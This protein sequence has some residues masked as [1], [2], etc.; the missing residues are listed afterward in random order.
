MALTPS[1]RGMNVTG[2]S[3]TPTGGSA[4]LMKGMKS[5]KVDQNTIMVSEGGDGDYYDSFAVAAGA[6]PDCSIEVNQ[7]F[8]MIGAVPGPGVLLLNF[9]DAT[10][11]ALVGGGGYSATVTNA[12]Y[13]GTN[14]SGAHRTLTT[15]SYQFKTFSPDGQTNPI[16]FAAL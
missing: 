3:W 4:I 12:I 8:I 10:N 1:K 15:A 9:N 2:G 14:L 13:Q 16:T 5:A 7:P 6:S 11:A